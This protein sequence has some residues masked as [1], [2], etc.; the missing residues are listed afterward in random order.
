MLFLLLLLCPSGGAPP[1]PESVYNDAGFISVA[2][3]G[4]RLFYWLFESRHQP[5]RDPLIVWLSGG[6]GMA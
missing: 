3:L 2:P 1:G 5:D 6:P 4:R